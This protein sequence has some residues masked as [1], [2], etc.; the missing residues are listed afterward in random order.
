MRLF[1]QTQVV[2]NVYSRLVI[3]VIGSHLHVRID[4]GRELAGWASW[5]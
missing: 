5:D 2:Y 4:M 1:S 3:Q